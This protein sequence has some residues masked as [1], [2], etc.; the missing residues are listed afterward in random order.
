ML[1]LESQRQEVQTQGL[2]A[3][4]KQERMKSRQNVG[5]LKNRQFWDRAKDPQQDSRVERLSRL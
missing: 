5:G 4:V 3:G 2:R 1:Y